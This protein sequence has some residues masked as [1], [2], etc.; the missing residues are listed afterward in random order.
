MYA[1]AGQEAA[2]SPEE[3]S[4]PTEGLSRNLQRLATIAMRLVA[5]DA[6]GVWLLDEAGERWVL[7]ASFGLPE[8]H[9]IRFVA[10]PVTQ[11]DDTPAGGDSRADA[12]LRSVV[13]GFAT[14]FPLPLG[15]AAHPLGILLICSATARVFTLDDADRLR[16]LVE[17]G[18]AAIAADR[19][20][21]DLERAEARQSEFIRI[22]THEL[23]SPIT[24]SQS[25]IRTV[26]KGYAGPLTDKQRDVFRRI[27][28]QLD[29]LESLVNDLLDLAA[30]KAPASA[31]QG[32][33][34]MVNSS[35]GRAVLVLQPRADEQNIALTLRPC[36]DE[37]T[38]WATE[39]ALDR[40][41]VN[42]VGNAIKYTPP[43]GQVSV[44]L[45]RVQ[46][47]IQV[48]VSDTGIGIPPE[49][50]PQLFQEFYRAPNAR[51][52]KATGTGLGLAIV[53]QLV[54]RFHGRITV[55]S[56]VGQGTTF[57]VFFPLY[58]C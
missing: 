30:S 47:E 17:L 58:A 52:V 10:I 37:L 23:R 13:P 55:E 14:T 53:K 51:S 35:V 24:V 28:G 29:A 36:C 9:G 25:L 5:A 50:L 43:G 57:T 32:E 4:R 39:E 33:P 16:P 46:D 41:F 18:A 2:V 45:R 7:A 48:S 26:I 54:D 8:S 19:R 27:S 31:V 1:D 11:G 38:V 34:V 21:A 15:P 40:I 22:S 3:P 12:S 49:S 20:L 44:T 56:T 42:L 6:A